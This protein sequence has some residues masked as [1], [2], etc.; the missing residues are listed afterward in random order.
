MSYL[1]FRRINTFQ[2]EEDLTSTVSVVCLQFY[3]SGHGFIVNSF[4]AGL[5]LFGVILILPLAGQNEFKRYIAV[6]LAL[7]KFDSY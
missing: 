1:V 2:D 7:G 3:H 4:T 6:T 5:N